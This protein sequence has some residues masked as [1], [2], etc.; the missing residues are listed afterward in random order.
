MT[1]E[2]ITVGLALC[3]KRR[4]YGKDVIENYWDKNDSVFLSFVQFS[5]ERTKALLHLVSYTCW[6]I[7]CFC[8]QSRCQYETKALLNIILWAQHSI[9]LSPTEGP[10]N[11]RK[12]FK[13][14]SKNQ[15]GKLPLGESEITNF[16]I[17]HILCRK[18]S[19]TLLRFPDQKK[20]WLTKIIRTNQHLIRGS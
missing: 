4:R 2:P 19:V 20:S 7:K 18:R 9:K 8:L 15:A 1:G 5:W 14:E 13:S 16:S 17:P 10:S 12:Q 3:F 6:N 11:K